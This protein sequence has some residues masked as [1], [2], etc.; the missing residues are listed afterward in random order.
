MSEIVL[1]RNI[2][3]SGIHLRRL[4]ATGVFLAISLVLRM[5]ASGY[6]TLFGTN[7]ARVG[8]HGVFTIMPAILFG[9]WYGAVAS[10]L[11]DLLG[12]FMRPMG[13]WLW[14]MTIIMA[15]GGFI[16]G[17]AW[18]LLRGRSPF[19]TR[20]VV[21]AL[22]IAFLAFGS[23]SMMQL[24]QEGITRSFYDDIEDPTAVD[25]SQMNYISRLVIS[26]TQNTR[27]PDV[28]LAGRIAETAYAPL[29]AGVLGIVL[30]GIDFF[31]TKRLEK[32]DKYRPHEKDEKYRNYENAEPPLWQADEGIPDDVIGVRARFA[33][34]AAILC[35]PWNGS[36][37][38]LALTI[39]LV[40]L[41]INT[42]N[43]VLM[44]AVAVPAWSAFPFMYIW[45][46]RAVVA[47]L[48]S[49]VNVFIAVLLMGVCY[50]QPHM[51]SLIE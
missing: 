39:I 17:W 41:L 45:L 32:D 18:R 1:R 40:S 27:E 19:S 34:M 42:A 10:G 5:T 12:H 8:I 46:P 33:K 28:Q 23:F 3:K 35:A 6:V 21:V 37:M 43:S 38:P 50:K 30:L 22:T 11:G 26:R 9:P 2:T 24:Q 49:A 7:G 4:V 36:I 47:L 13:A 29:G 44:W 31:L 25:T 15:V 20:G 16:R 48:N 51:K 14:Q